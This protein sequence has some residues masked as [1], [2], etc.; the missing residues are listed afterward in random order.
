MQKMHNPAFGLS[1]LAKGAAVQ[2]NLNGGFHFG[3]QNG[4][5]NRPTRTIRTI[6]STFLI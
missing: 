2:G 4:A 5:L 6:F 1:V 3:P